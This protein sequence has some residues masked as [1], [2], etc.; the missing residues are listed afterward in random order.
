MSLKALG[1]CIAVIVILHLTWSV[2]SRYRLQLI[3]DLFSPQAQTPSKDEKKRKADGTP[4]GRGR[5][6][7][8]Q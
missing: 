5:K 6:K 4:D 2:S 3:F 7:K 8:K 1:S